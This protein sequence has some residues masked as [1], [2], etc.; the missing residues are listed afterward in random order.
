MSK[1]T[2]GRSSLHLRTE[3]YHKR[4]SRLRDERYSFRD[5]DE[6]FP[7]ARDDLVR[8]SFDD[9]TAQGVETYLK[10][11][12]GNKLSWWFS[13]VLSESK[14]D[15][16]DIHYQGAL[17]KRTGELPRA[18]DQRHT[19]NVDANYRLSPKWHF[20]ITGQ[21]RSGWPDTEF[22]VRRIAREDGSFAYYQDRGVFRGS[23]VPSYQ[24][25]DARINRHFQTS[26]GRGTVFLHIINLYNHENVIRYDHDIADETTETFR[27]L[28]E[29]EPWFGITP[30]LGVSWEL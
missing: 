5:I 14:D 24:R 23:R 2:L 8:L 16:A 28:I 9:R 4:M 1:K 21:F 12:T 3:A 15:V 29:A 26:G 30:F 18:W 27:P 19:L 13:Y 11:D 7:E 25:L 17:V 22:T 10:Y 6:F 20:N